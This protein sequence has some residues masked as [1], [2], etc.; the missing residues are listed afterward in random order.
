MISIFLS[1][2]VVMFFISFLSPLT[3]PEEAFLDAAL[4]TLMVT[5]LLYLFVYRPIRLYVSELR[6]TQEALQLSEKRFRDIADNAF[7]WIWE[8]DS[9]GRY[10]YASHVVEKILGYEPEEVLGKYFYDLFHAEDREDLKTAALEVFKTKQP[11][12]E[13]INRNIHKNGDIV[14]LSTSGVPIVDEGGNLLGYRGSDA[15]ITVRKQAEE[16]L[17]RA[18]EE[19]KKTFDTIPDLILVTDN[20][21]KIVNVNKAMVERIGI[22]RED[23]IGKP[24]YE[25]VHGTAEPPS[26]C[27]HS[28]TLSDGKERIR[29]IYE[30]SLK[31]HFLVSST[32]LYDSYQK[33]YGVVEVARDI[34]ELKKLEEKLQRAVITDELTGLHNRRGFT[35]LSEQQLN[36]ASRDN[37]MLTLLY[38]DLDNMKQINDNFGHAAGDTALVDAAHILRNSFRKS[39]VIGRIGGD[40]FAVLLAGN[41][42]SDN[43]IIEHLR[44]NVRI[45]N[46][47]NERSYEL[48]LSTGIAHYD[49]EHSCTLDELLD[50]A[51]RAMYEQKN[52]K[53]KSRG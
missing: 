17:I 18:Q 33:P 2:T 30:D 52:L 27:P 19:W 26:Y 24:C 31:G 32:P 7:E 45:F 38:A 23:L 11:F 13:F 53:R 5:P 25:V 3:M 22:S 8:V 39:D 6:S 20:R 12:R 48:S 51:D 21:L 35:I 46:A 37:R 10:T 4:L 1:E 29:E 28:E 40:E 49:P 44:N 42:D 36:V 34:T 41:P 43:V 9:E 16:E 14:W 50:R 15:D 47:R